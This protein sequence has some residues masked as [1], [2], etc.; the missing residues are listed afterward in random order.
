[1]RL[2]LTVVLL[3]SG[4]AACAP[5][6]AEVGRAAFQDACAVCHGVRADG[7]GTMAPLVA[8]GVPN[9][10]LLKGGN[11]GVF[12]RDHVIRVVT[13]SSD[14]HPGIAPMPNFGTLLEAPG[15]VHRTAGDEAIATNTTI[16]AIADYLESIQD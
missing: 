5:Q 10:R 9:L 3:C 8:T 6:P 16:L 13:R 4:V 15:A 11:G 7:N 14:F 2:F 12:P 1:M